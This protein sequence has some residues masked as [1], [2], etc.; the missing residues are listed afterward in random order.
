MC[1]VPSRLYVCVVSSCLCVRYRVVC[2]RYRGVVCGRYGAKLCVRYL[3]VMP[4]CACVCVCVCVC[5][6]GLCVPVR[7]TE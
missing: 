3:Y 6:T 1:V 2:D 4:N 7:D 5:G